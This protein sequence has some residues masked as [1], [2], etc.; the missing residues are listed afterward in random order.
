MATTL[1]LCSQVLSSTFGS[2]SPSHRFTPFKGDFAAEEYYLLLRNAMTPQFLDSS[3]IHQYSFYPANFC[4]TMQ[5]HNK[6][7]KFDIPLQ[8]SCQCVSKGIPP[9]HEVTSHRTQIFHK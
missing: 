8:F 4:I 2:F 5:V 9:Y 6:T 1:L 7:F 3:S